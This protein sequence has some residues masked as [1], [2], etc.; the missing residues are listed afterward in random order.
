MQIYLPEMFN[1]KIF[2][3]TITDS[4]VGLYCYIGVYID[5]VDNICK[6]AHTYVLIFSLI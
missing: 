6:N 2:A 5:N 4:A 3:R 1:K